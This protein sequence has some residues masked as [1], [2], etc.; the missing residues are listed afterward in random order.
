MIL[1][2]RG[3]TLWGMFAVIFVGG[4]GQRLRPLTE[5]VPKPMVKVDGKPILEYS[6]EWVKMAGVTDIIFCTGYKKEAIEEYFGNGEKFGVRIKYLED[7]TPGEGSFAAARDALSQ[8]PE[9]EP[10]VIIMAGDVMTNTNPAE[11][12]RAHREGGNALTVYMIR[13]VVPLGVISENDRGLITDLKAKPSLIANSAIGVT[14]TNI[15]RLLREG[16]GDFF[17]ESI[18]QLPGLVR[19]H[20]DRESRWW[21]VSDVYDLA[22][23]N[24]EVR[25]IRQSQE[26]QQGQRE[27]F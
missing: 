13:H 22:R 20:H 3:D 19:T 16:Q 18:Q 23:V 25:Q 21:H 15:F 17:D 5:K 8:I 2:S 27:R 12:V 9:S 4:E 7:V 11:L 1:I 24:K 14:N 6:V 10:D 26:G